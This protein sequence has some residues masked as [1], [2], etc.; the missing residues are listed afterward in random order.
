MMR[1]CYHMPGETNPDKFRTEAQARL[2]EEKVSTVIHHH[3]RS[4]K[5]ENKTHEHIDVN[6]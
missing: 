2:I 3:K 1:H 4:E 6:A 5:C